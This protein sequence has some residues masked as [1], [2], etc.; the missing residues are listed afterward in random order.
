MIVL[1]ANENATTISS[2]KA[3]KIDHFPLTSYIQL[4]TINLTAGQ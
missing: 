1:R 2:S 4:Q 3:Q